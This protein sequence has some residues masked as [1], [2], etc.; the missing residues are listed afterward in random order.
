M[1]LQLLTVKDAF[2]YS[3]PS[4]SQTY[5]QSEGNNNSRDAGA[6]ENR[7]KHKAAV[8]REVPRRIREGEGKTD[9]GENS[10]CDFVVNSANVMSPDRLLTIPR[11]SESSRTRRTSRTS[12]TMA[13]SRRKPRWNDNART[14]KSLTIEVG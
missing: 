5:P 14:L 4:I 3:I 10:R 8:K 2:I 9:T 1:M 13:T 11:P 7:R 6:E 12:R